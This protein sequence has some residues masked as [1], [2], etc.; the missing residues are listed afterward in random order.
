MIRNS[1][2]RPIALAA[3]LAVTAALAGCAPT[4]I[5]GRTAKSDGVMFA[6]SLSPAAAPHHYSV[7]LALQDTAS[8]EAIDN[9]GVAL[10]LFGPG[11][12]EDNLVNLHRDARIQSPTYVADIDLP[13]AATYQLTFQVNRPA[14]ASSA[15]ATFSTA[16]PAG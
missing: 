3:A 15:Q 8:G 7:A 16:R 13:R 12:A 4:A 2:V 5:T 10:T 9:A 6:Y 14:P 11:V 1:A